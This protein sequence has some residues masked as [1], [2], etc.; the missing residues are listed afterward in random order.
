MRWVYSTGDAVKVA[1][2]FY[3]A[4]SRHFRDNSQIAVIIP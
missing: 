4:P 3:N 1:L 2:L